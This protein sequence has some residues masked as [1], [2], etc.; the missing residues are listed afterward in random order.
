MLQYYEYLLGLKE[1]LI[2]N[3]VNQKHLSLEDRNYIEQALNQNLSF[4]DIAKFLSKDPTTISKEVKKHRTRKEATSFN[5][6]FN[7]CINR[8]HCSRKYVCGDLFC[9]KK[10][11]NC[12][13]CNRFCSEFEE[14]LCL[15]LKQ[16]PYVCNP[17]SKKNGCHFIKFYYKALPSFN[18]YKHILSTSR[19]GI[20]LPSDELCEL[21]NI[22]SPLIKQG[23]SI[24]HIYQTQDLKCSK[25][26]LY[27]YIQKQQLSVRNIDLPR[28]VRFKA[29]KK[30]RDLPKDTTIRKG[31]TYEDFEKYL[32]E[33]PDVSIVEMDTV[34]GKKGGKVLLTFL[35]RNSKLMLA[36][37][38][39]DK[40]ADTV[41]K[42]FDYLESI[43]GNNLFEKTF[44]VILT[45]NGT[46][47]SNP[48]RLEFNQEGIGRTRI[49]FCNPGASYQ[50]GALEKNHE[51]IRY[52]IPKGTPMDDLTQ[53]DIEKMINHIN[54]ITRKSLNGNTPLDLASLLLDKTVLKKLNLTKV[55]AS[56]VKLTRNLLKKN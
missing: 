15:S 45:D 48:L 33:N 27:N 35:F 36:F 34:E 5:T 46:E 50:K 26:S 6:N 1:V 28:R 52:V 43:L 42:V 2:M 8:Y 19:Q 29:R 51:F 53:K 49:F 12:I 25:S 14:E 7:Q 41:I 56:E 55:P 18:N 32:L 23:Q 3:N 31:R 37:L 17:C 24:A 54:S 13:S 21:D 39:K 16:P 40:S 30:K 38:M 9:K 4:K 47:F 10:C 44:P 22:V 11:S 20:N